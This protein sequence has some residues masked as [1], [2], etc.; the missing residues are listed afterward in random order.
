[1]RLD[2]ERSLVLKGIANQVRR[3]Q[4]LTLGHG[5]HEVGPPVVFLTCTVDEQR[6]AQKRERLGEGLVIVIQA[7]LIQARILLEIVMPI[8]ATPRQECFAQETT[9]AN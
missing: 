7:A 9:D 2:I 6:F 4:G 5:C 3:D 8:P 1:M